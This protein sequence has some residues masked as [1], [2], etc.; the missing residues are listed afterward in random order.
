MSGAFFFHGVQFASRLYGELR[1]FDF[2]ICISWR[3]RT[4]SLTLDL[5]GRSILLI[6]L[7]L[8]V[9]M[10]GFSLII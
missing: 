6:F 4:G 2:S 3:Y 10:I 1:L 8:L 7:I 5:F 9:D